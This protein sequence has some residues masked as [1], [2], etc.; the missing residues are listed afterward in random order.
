MKPSGTGLEWW[1]S[2][3]NHWL[4]LQS[5]LVQLPPSTWQ[6]T[7][8]VTPVPEDQVPSPSL[9]GHCTHMVHIRIYKQNR[10]NKPFFKIWGVICTMSSVSLHFLAPPSHSA[11]EVRVRPTAVRPSASA[12]DEWDNL[13][14]LSLSTMWVLETELRSSALAAST[15]TC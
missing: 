1:L 2:G 11:P 15:F 13:C 9:Q 5:T 8:T 10:R 7:T 6:P 12:S 4:V 14:Q 3:Y